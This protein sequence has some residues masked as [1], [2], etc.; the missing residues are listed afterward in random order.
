V[1]YDFNDLQVGNQVEYTEH[2]GF[3]GRLI[4]KDIKVL[5]IEEA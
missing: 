5:G 4:A 3:D 2:V 1:N